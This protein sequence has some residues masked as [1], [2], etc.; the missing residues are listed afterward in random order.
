MQCTYLCVFLTAAEGQHTLSKTVVS[1]SK[2]GLALFA[3]KKATCIGCRAL[4]SQ[5]GEW[6]ELYIEINS[7]GL[8]V[9]YALMQYFMH[10]IDSSS[11]FYVLP[12]RD[13]R[14]QALQG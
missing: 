6:K 9:S 8:R 5:G 14:L 1:S 10:R 7:L 11:H 3:T 13:S 4:L 2:G 12:C